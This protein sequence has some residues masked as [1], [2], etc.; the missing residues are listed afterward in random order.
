M[1][2]AEEAKLLVDRFYL[3]LP[4]NGGFTELCNINQRWKEGK[5]CALIAVTVIM[6]TLFEA[7]L[8]QM[9]DYWFEVKKEIEKIHD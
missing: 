9:W 4:N 1:T 3:S 2:P 8:M 6:E 7:D 5:Q